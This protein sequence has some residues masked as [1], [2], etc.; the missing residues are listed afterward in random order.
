MGG[1][2]G[3]KGAD[4]SRPFCHNDQYN[5]TQSTPAFNADEIRRDFN[6]GGKTYKIVVGSPVVQGR[7]KEGSNLATSIRNR[8]R[9]ID[10]ARRL[11]RTLGVKTAGAVDVYLRT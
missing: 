7:A 10:E 11:D 3:T 2:A 8:G 6:A 9:N 5:V 1:Q 4:L